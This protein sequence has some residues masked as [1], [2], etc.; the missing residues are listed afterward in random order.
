MR[1]IIRPVAPLLVC[2]V[3]GLVIAVFRAPVLGP[4]GFGF[5]SVV[6]GLPIYGLYLL[7]AWVQRRSNILQG[8]STAHLPTKEEYLAEHEL[9]L[10]GS[11]WCTHCGGQVVA[12]EHQ[13]DTG[14]WVA[15]SCS[16]CRRR[17]Y[18]SIT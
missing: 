4:R 7:F 5:M 13:P 18:R 6:Y 3:I 15:Y 14:I 9:P 10:D 1:D 16:Q 11:V 2:M 12:D 8:G 17:L